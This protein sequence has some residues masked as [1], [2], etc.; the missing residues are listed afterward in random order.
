MK[1]PENN[2]RTDLQGEKSGAPL[3]A[4]ELNAFIPGVEGSNWNQISSSHHTPIRLPQPFRHSKM[5]AYPLP[6]GSG[7]KFQVLLLLKISVPSERYRRTGNPASKM[8]PYQV[9]SGSRP[10]FPIARLKPNQ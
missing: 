9:L 1:P 5:L 7:T 4:K 3:M 8:L 2:T 10:E 6:H